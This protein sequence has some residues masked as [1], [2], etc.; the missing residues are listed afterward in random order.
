MTMREI[1]NGIFYLM[2]AGCPWRRSPNTA[3]LVALAAR[4]RLM[5]F[6]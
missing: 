6:S 1:V 5:E 4:D 3:R 2:R